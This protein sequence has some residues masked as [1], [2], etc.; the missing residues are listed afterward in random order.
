MGSSWLNEGEIKK[1]ISSCSLGV[2]H[3]PSVQRFPLQDLLPGLLVVVV[4]DLN[5]VGHIF[6]AKVI[7]PPAPPAGHTHTGQTHNRLSQQQIVALRS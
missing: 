7:F 4:V 2:H 5:D 6:G 3:Q 1:K